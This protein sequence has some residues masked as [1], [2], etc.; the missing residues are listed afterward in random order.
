MGLNVSMACTSQSKPAHVL[1]MSLDAVRADHLGVYGD[2]RNLTP[3]LDAIARKSVVFESAF[4]PEPWTL[5]AH[6][7]M[8]TGLH[9]SV[10]GVHQDQGLADE[11]MTLAEAFSS[12][13]FVTKA[14]VADVPWMSPRF[15]QYQGFQEVER[16]KTSTETTARLV[17]DL[18]GA[19]QPT[20]VFAHL[21]DAHS[22]TG[23]W[24]YEADA[25]DR[26][27]L[28]LP[29]RPPECHPCGSSLLR[30]HNEGRPLS[31]D[32]IESVAK[33]YAASIR[34]LDRRLGSLFEKLEEQGVLERMVIVIT[35]DH[36]EELAE[37]GRFL[38]DQFFDEVTRVPLLI[39]QPH[40]AASRCSALVSLVDIAPTIGD[41]VGVSFSS[42]DGVSVAPLLDDCTEK[43]IRS[44]VLF[45]THTGLVGVRTLNHSLIGHGGTWRLH[46]LNDD[47]GQ[48][49]NINHTAQ[50]V[51]ALP[52]LRKLLLDE[53][54]RLAQLRAGY[55]TIEA[56]PQIS[57]ADLKRLE[58]LGYIKP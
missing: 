47:P 56:P 36:G 7:S 54:Q 53:Q 26:E 8:L 55:P 44:S 29:E 41:L 43:E 1:L 25:Q 28:G 19:Q 13:G 38:H 3:N 11:V 24:P 39:H 9:P 52:A 51:A 33:G 12:G 30:S 37:H 57:K 20:M 40:T 23:P 42:N 45:D 48:R 14:M 58:E 17:S 49:A 31:P 15:G 50:G 32:A 35:S 27:A 18:S 16:H 2:N 6:T 10:H 21:Y 22:D 5:P 4:T 46:N 34:S